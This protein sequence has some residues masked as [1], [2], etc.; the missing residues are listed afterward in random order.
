MAAGH[1][2]STAWVE[3]ALGTTTK[4]W[5]VTVDG[6]KLFAFGVLTGPNPLSWTAYDSSGH[7]V[8]WPVG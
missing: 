7:A 2:P 5:P 1:P 3:P 6:Q 8:A 4:V